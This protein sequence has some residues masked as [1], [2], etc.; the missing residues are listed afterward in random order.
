MRAHYADLMSNIGVFSKASK[1]LTN[2]LDALTETS[3]TTVTPIGL[4]R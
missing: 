4:G 1:P 2:I 3:S